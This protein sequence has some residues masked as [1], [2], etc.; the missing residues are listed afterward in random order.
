MGKTLAVCSGRG[1]EGKTTVALSV[2]VG[3]AKKGLSV[4]LLDAS[5][6]GR[7]SDL[8]LGMESV[9]ALDMADVAVGEATIH[10]ALYPISRYPGLHLACSSLTDEAGISSISS[11]ILILQ[12]L[13]DLLVIDL[14]AGI[15]ELGHGVLCD[16]DAMIMVLKPEEA[17]LRS[18][19]RL[20]SRLYHGGAPVY[21][22]LNHVSRELR[23][24]RVQ[25]EPEAIQMVLDCTFIAQIP[26]DRSIPL[27]AAKGKPAIECD[28]P[29]WKTLSRLTEDVIHAS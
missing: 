11:A 25:M 19:E 29:A 27:G 28:G 10:A 16:Q 5:G 14:P 18:C 15:T 17:S 21:Y 20:V 24:Q 3:A 1:G 26:D 12:S 9:I 13:C 2:A 7:T 22:V 4:I 23:K 8:I 6:A